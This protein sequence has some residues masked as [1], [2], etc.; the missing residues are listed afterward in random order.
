[1]NSDHQKFYIIRQIKHINYQS[2]LSRSSQIQKYKGQKSKKYWECDQ[3]INTIPQ[4]KIQ[5]KCFNRVLIFYCF[6]FKFISSQLQK[7][8]SQ[9]LN[10]VTSLSN[11]QTKIDQH[12]NQRKLQE[13]SKLQELFQMHFQHQI[14]QIQPS[15]LKLQYY[16][17]Q[18]ISTQ[19]KQNTNKNINYNSTSSLII[20]TYHPIAY[21]LLNNGEDNQKWY[22]YRTLSNKI[23]KC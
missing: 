10:I 5:R 16:H 23:C 15:I 4:S 9:D 3:N 7:H 12:K 11:P 20:Q 13:A 21:Q 22:F 1:M 18:T 8:T 17:T 19:S 6:Y 2:L 14:T